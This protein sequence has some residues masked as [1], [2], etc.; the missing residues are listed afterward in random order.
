MGLYTKKKRTLSAMSAF[1]LW[2]LIKTSV[3]LY[4]PVRVRK[5]IGLVNKK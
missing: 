3:K 1:I 2:S 4:Q 5:P